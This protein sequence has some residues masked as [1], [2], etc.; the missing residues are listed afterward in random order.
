LEPINIIKEDPRNARILYVGTDHGVYLSLDR[1]RTFMRMAKNL[2]SV[3]VHDLVVHPRDNELIVGTHGRSLYIA[4]L[5]HVQQLTDTIIQKP[6]HAFLLRNITYHPNWGRKSNNWA[7]PMEPTLTIPYYLKSAGPVTVR[8]K[9]QNG[10]LIKEFTD[11]GE[12]GLNYAPYDLS[13][14]NVDQEKYLSYLNENR[15]KDNPEIKFT[16]TDTQKQYLRPGRYL[17]ELEVNGIRQTRDFLVQGL[18]NQTR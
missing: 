17:I 14:G 10:L 6:L 9:T 11:T 8:V 16:P 5:E 3:A 13:I 2:P 1:G 12:P 18:E 4:S 7:K 15:K